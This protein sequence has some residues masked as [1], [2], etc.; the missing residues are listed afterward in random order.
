M[1]LSVKEVS[2]MAHVTIKTLHH[3]H[4]IGLLKPTEIS[5]AGYRLYGEKELQRLQEILFYRELEFSLDQIKE[6][7]NSNPDRKSILEKQEALLISKSQR[8]DTL[9]DTIKLTITS[10]KEGITMENNQLFAGFANER[11]WNEALEEQS[12][13]L[14]ETY[15]MEPLKVQEA[16]VQTMNEQAAEAVTFMSNMAESLRAGLKHNEAKIADYIKNHLD[17]LN[18]H[19]HKLS[20][21]DF[22][23]QTKFF[24]QDDFHLS[25]LE[26]QQ[27]GLAYYL[28]A[29]AEAYQAQSKR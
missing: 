28:A 7:M 10:M 17:F 4:K 3:Y 16:D 14:E 9:I 19:G 21:L 29:A 11:Q 24:L 12:K 5:E 27:T 22:A 13:Y 25:M 26:A 18:R 2:E 20:A 15:G 6:I 23:S 1:L 8:L